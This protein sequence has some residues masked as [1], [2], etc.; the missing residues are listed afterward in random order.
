M[1]K[2]KFRGILDDITPEEQEIWRQERIADRKKLT[3]EYQFGYYLGEYIYD[4]FLP[5]LSV[6]MLRSRKVIEVTKEEEEEVKRLND[7]WYPPE[8]IG[9]EKSKERKKEWEDLRAYHKML[10]DKYLPKELKC[11]VPVLNVVNEKEFKD[12]L[13]ASL[14]DTDLCHYSLKPENIKIEYDEDDYF[15]YI[16]LLKG[17]D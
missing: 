12:G 3:A 2:S 4:N 13:I 1:T 5:T 9:Y 11:H 15:S 8:E 16:V 10:E 14:W 6:D 7:L 17:D